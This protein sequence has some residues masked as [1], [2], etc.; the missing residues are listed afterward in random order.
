M[1]HLTSKLQACQKCEVAGWGAVNQDPKDPIYPTPLR[2]LGISGLK[3]RVLKLTFFW[4]KMT[5]KSGVE[6]SQ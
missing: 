6:F 5:V 1:G 2:T 3:S 4:L